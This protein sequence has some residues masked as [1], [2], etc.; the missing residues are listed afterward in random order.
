MPMQLIYMLQ[1]VAAR[2]C[3]SV[4]YSTPCTKTLPAAGHLNHTKSIW[5]MWAPHAGLSP[6]VCT[7]RSHCSVPMSSSPLTRTLHDMQAFALSTHLARGLE[8]PNRY[9]L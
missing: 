1:Q 6:D 3:C 7:M 8:V 5:E 2:C 9:P 4:G